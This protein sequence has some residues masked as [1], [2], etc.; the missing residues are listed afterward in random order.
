MS[1]SLR[2]L[3]GGWRAAMIAAAIALLSPDTA[4]A[5]CGD[6]ITYPNSSGHDPSA[7]TNDGI[8]PM[9]LPCEGPNCSNKREREFPPAPPAPVSSPTKEQA[10]PIAAAPDR[11]PSGIRFVLDLDSPRPIHR[12]TSI[13]HPPRLG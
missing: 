10:R 7:M 6:Y 3:I 9:K 4:S 12:S 1:I 13:F 2:H 5:G 8:M 11:D